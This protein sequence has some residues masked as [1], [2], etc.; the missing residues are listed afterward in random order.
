MSHPFEE[1]VLQLGTNILSEGKKSFTSKLS[2]SN[3]GQSILDK[4]M[5][6]DNFRTS[7]LRFTDV[8]PTLKS[9]QEFM[10]HLTAYFG[11]SEGLAKFIG[12][13]L[14][15]G[16]LLD[17]IIAPLGRR[18]IKAIASQFIA[19]ET[20]N[21]GITAF[22]K[23]HRSGVACSIDIL[24]EAVLSKAESE[25][26]FE[27]YKKAIKNISNKA[28]KWAES[29]Y[30]EQDSYGKIARTNVSVKLSALYEHTSPT[31][32]R[33]SLKVLTS[34]LSELLRLAQ[35]KN[36]FINIDME[37]FELLPLTLE[38][39][40]NVIC[41]DEF[42][43]Y[44]HIGIVCQAYL[45][46]GEH[47]L[48]HL[49]SIAQKRGTPFSIRLVKGAYWDYEQAH[50]EQQN[51]P[52]PVF[53]EK[54]E[55]DI[56]FEKL[57]QKLI[58]NFPT[59]RPCIASHNARSLA[60]AMASAEEAKLQKSD[61]EFQMLY[62]MAEEF[63]D[64]LVKKG[65]RVRQYCP[66]GEFIPGMSYLV[67]RLLEN[68]ANQNF[69]KSMKG[70]ENK[71]ELL[72][73][74]KVKEKEEISKEGFRNHP[75]KDFS[76]PANRSKAEKSLAYLEGALPLQIEP[77]MREKPATNRLEHPCPWNVEKPVTN[78]GLATK[79]EA[80][81]AIKT[82]QNSL[83][84]WQSMGVEK[85]SQIMQEA[86]R[87]TAEKWGELF[88]LQVFEAGKDWVSADADICE[89]ID[90]MNYY[91]EQAKKLDQKN[92]PTSL[93]GESN[94]ITHEALGV[95]SVIAPW[96]FPFAISAGMTAAALVT[97]NTV[98]YKPAEQTTAIGRALYDIFIEAGVPAGALHFLPG[99]GE[100]VGARIVEHPQT[101]AIAF[102]GSREVGLNIIENAAKHQQGQQHIKKTI[103]ELGGKNAIIVDSDADLDE[104]VPAVVHSAFAFQGQKCS[105]C[106]RVI[107]VGSA[108]KN[109]TKRLAEMVEELKVGS[110]ANP[111]FQANA[112]I[113]EEA[114]RKTQ[115]YLRIGKKD[116]KLLAQSKLEETK[117]YFI[118]PTVFTDLTKS[119]RLTK[120]EVFGPILCVYKAKTIEEAVNMALDND[121]AL[122]GALFSRHPESI[123]YV[124]QNYRV[125]NLY[126]N[127]GCT[128]AL[129]GRQPF[130]GGKL[131]GTNSKAGG[132]DY[133]HHFTSPRITTENTMRRGYA[134]K[135]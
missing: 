95:V 86:A 21:E 52:C 23:L 73:P 22:E 65:Y 47:I 5:D 61:I 11:Q 90:F 35:S 127:R 70:G 13:N 38:V 99:L 29:K 93:W 101:A 78:L 120:E 9:D 102:T 85:R 131:S 106:S 84:E 133:L 15:T 110:P 114:Y 98:I 107:V 27:A 6:N 37:Q 54:S 44:P 32:H 42:K 97:G 94:S 67:R 76:I 81:A 18:N 41:K 124:K 17:K 55:T 112:L 53:D 72:A 87:L 130:G 25:H 56:N 26:F 128:G 7:A 46:D 49:I 104:A 31:G 48:N 28:S 63:R 62:G 103:V 92:Q 33:D 40:E 88:A 20:I 16:G 10:Q 75:L 129:V 64:V 109:F 117:G 116:G 122:T 105:A 91:A 108:Y 4:M 134:P 115:S 1:R 74:P 80:D 83:Q 45:R 96:N 71:L 36:A 2:P 118:P 113:D 24:G 79:K 58:N 135:E 3:W 19:G 89:G 60:V 121:Y 57:T 111:E 43:D 8:A 14:P 51:W 12:G 132:A 125:G 34:R 39:F 123:D 66:I 30:P 68:T 59:V 126:I 82:A 119:S 69:L 77:S 100:E 50:A